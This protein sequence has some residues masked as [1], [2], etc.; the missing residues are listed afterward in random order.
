M[1]VAL[2]SVV[3]VRAIG[4]DVLAA[5]AAGE[6][7]RFDARVVAGPGPRDC[8][9]WVGAIS[10]DGYG[11]FAVRRAGRELVVRPHRWA[12]AVAG[13]AFGPAEVAMHLCDEPIC[14][15]A[16]GPAAHVVVASQAEN[17]ASAWA[18]DRMGGPWRRWAGGDRAAMAQRS[19]A[20][21]AAARD[22]WD[23]DRLRAAAD[24]VP[25][26]RGLQPLF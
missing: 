1:S 2:P 8:W 26:S 18:K 24:S 25:A 19:R 14:V 21:R 4:A 5:V 22:G 12:L 9:L 16:S 3:W 7:E 23:A 20:L 10:D 13:E 6:V 17:L 15:R 11:R